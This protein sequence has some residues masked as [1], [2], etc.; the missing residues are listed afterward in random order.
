MIADLSGSTDRP[1]TSS[2]N[3]DR[4]IAHQPPRAIGIDGSPINLLDQSG[5][6]DRPSTSSINRDRPIAHQPLRSIA[7]DGSAINLLDRNRP[8]GHQPPRSE[9]SF[10]NS[11]V[12]LPIVSNEMRWSI[13]RVTVCQ[14]TS[15][16]RHSK[17]SYS[18]RPGCI[19]KG[20]R[21]EEGDCT[22]SQPIK[23]TK[24]HGVLISSRLGFVEMSPT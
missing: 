21:I 23:A 22:S 14:W 19:L 9:S 5:S 12:F 7:I 16:D 2:S 10:L 15:T 17:R 8:I 6:T 11:R 13:R 4:P 1:S 24:S 20:V 3:R 18:I